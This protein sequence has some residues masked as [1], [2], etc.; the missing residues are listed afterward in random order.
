MTKTIARLWNGDLEPAKHVGKNNEEAKELQ[1]LIQRNGERLEKHLD[2]K[3]KE[4][5]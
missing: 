1:R 2:Q 3:A 4:Y 5:F